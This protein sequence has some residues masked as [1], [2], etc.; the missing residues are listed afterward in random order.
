MAFVNEYVSQEDIKKY[1]LAELHRRCS[2]K[3]NNYNAARDGLHDKSQW[4]IDREREIWFM[5]LGIR[6]IPGEIPPIYLGNDIYILHYKGK[7]IEVVMEDNRKDGSTK[8][9]D[10]PFRIRWDI[11]S[12]SSSLLDGVQT[13]EIIELIQEAMEVYGLSGVGQYE[14]YPMKKGLILDVKVRYRGDN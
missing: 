14:E 9:S 10:N 6:K 8:F 11:L 4:T 13:E 1:G 5:R 2:H 3:A 12:I 7:N